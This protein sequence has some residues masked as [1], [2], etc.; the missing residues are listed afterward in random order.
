MSVGLGY[1]SKDRPRLGTYDGMS[2]KG[3]V[4]P[5]RRADQQ[6]DDDDRHLVHARRA[7][8]R[9]GDA[10]AARRVAAPGQHR[11]V[12]RIQPDRA[13]RAVHRVHRGAGHRHAR[14]SA[15][16]RRRRPRSASRIS[17]RCAT[18]S[19]AGFHKILG[20]GTDFR[21]TFKNEDKQGDRL[22]GRG[23]AP[24]FAAEPIDSTTR[25]LEAVLA[26]AGKPFQVQGGYYGSWY[27]NHNS[28]VDTANIN[29]A[30]VTS[31]PFFLSLPLDNQAHQLFVNGG[32]SL[33]ERTRAHV[34]GG[35]HARHAG[36]ADPGRHRRGGVRRRADAPER[37]AR[38]HAAAGRAHFA[39][40]QR[41]LLARQPALLR[42]DEK[43]PQVRVIQTGR[44]LRH[45]RR[46]H[47]AALRDHHRQARRHLPHGAGPERARRH[48]V[49]TQDRD[50][51]FGNANAAGLD[52]QRY[53]PWR[54][55]MDETTYRARAAALARRN[56]ERPHRLPVQPARR[57][58][59]HA[60][61]QPTRRSPT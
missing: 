16:R 8:P 38:H 36:R 44:R 42:L 13:R 4:R 61:T 51:P 45:L 47:A 32:Y 31:N 9:P 25:Q 39:R 37:P 29:A 43:T 17:A 12:P 57:L 27:T 28:L 21:F 58:G 56:V 50:V 20:G 5:A 11:R 15:C 55:E 48:R 34:Q 41:L 18:P 24:E 54:A 2:Q 53:V 26:Y 59:V 60:G 19:A 33:S 10:R 22:W 52:A 6:R 30:G 23:G 7:Q 46:Q 49:L 1:W 3:A 40:H 35:L 14:R